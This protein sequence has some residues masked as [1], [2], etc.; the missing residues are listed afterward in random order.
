[1]PLTS[2]DDVER[3]SRLSTLPVEKTLL[4]VVLQSQN[5]SAS[6]SKFMEKKF[7]VFLVFSQPSSI[8]TECRKRYQKRDIDVCKFRLWLESA[9]LTR[10]KKTRRKKDF[11][12]EDIFQLYFGSKLLQTS[13][14]F[15]LLEYRRLDI[16][17]FYR[18]RR[19]KHV[20]TSLFALK[21]IFP[22]RTG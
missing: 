15:C 17:I 12:A 9:S 7:P 21:N 13:K 18:F 8:N 5:F 4:L 3:V 10:K 11:N 20:I 19:L 22:L 2:I 16:F 14:R 6:H 1:M